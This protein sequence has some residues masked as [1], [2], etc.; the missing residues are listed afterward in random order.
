MK[1]NEIIQSL[2]NIREDDLCMSGF[3]IREM[4][5]ID[6]AIS[7][8]DKIGNVYDLLAEHFGDCSNILESHEEVEAWLERIRWNNRKC[9]E[10]ARKLEKIE[11]VAR[12]G[13]NESRCEK[14]LE[15]IGG[16]NENDI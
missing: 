9:D 10:L 5:I 8:L 2:R 16:E 13:K 4:R 7:E 6:D 11:Q 1:R 12:E 3:T 15:I 14:I